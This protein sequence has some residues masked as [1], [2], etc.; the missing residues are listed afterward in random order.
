MQNPSTKQL[1]FV[2]IAIFA[3]LALIFSLILRNSFDFRGLSFKEMPGRRPVYDTEGK[4]LPHDP[5]FILSS[6]I[7]LAQTPT[8]ARLDMP[9]GS[10]HGALTYDSQPFLTLNLQRN[11]KHLGDDFNGI[12]GMDTD[13]GDPVYSIGAGR[14]VYSGDAES[15]WGNVLMIAHR[16]PDGSRLQS[17][18][19]HLQRRD[20]GVGTDVMRG[21]AI[22]A[23]GMGDG[24]YPAHLHFEV[25]DSFSVNPGRGYFSD[26]MNRRDPSGTVENG[27][28]APDDLLNQAPQEPLTTP[29]IRW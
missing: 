19:G 12:G 21:E 25:R 13:L 7:D 28:C 2:T 11:G 15:G 1:I 10:E 26:A 17:F 27:R 6:P 23:V 14:V 8:A 22:G 29:E 3:A 4:A 24:A 9:L 5:A 16:L 18:Y 20:V